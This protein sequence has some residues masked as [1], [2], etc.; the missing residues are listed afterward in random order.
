MF[1]LG[2]LWLAVI[3]TVGSGQLVSAQVTQTQNNDPAPPARGGNQAS[4]RSLRGTVS[5][6]GKPING[7]V[8]QLKDT[9]TL[10]IRSYVTQNDGTYHF[11]GLSTNVSYEVH[12]ESNGASSPTKTLSVYDEHREAKIDLKLKS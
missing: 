6:S 7:A 5:R 3:L 2:K 10:Q 1:R 11:H 4:T 8:V 12:A 9:K